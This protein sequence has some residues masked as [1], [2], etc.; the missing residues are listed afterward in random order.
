MRLIIT[1]NPGTGKTQVAEWLAK[2]LR[3]PLLSLTSFILLKKLYTRRGKQREVALGR[4]RRALLPVIRKNP[5]LIVEGHL[6]CEIRL[7]VDWVVV[8]RCH[9]KILR[10][11]LKKRRYP[12]KKLEEN[13]LAEM[14]DYTTQRAR[15]NYTVPILEIDTAHRSVGRAGRKILQ[16]IRLKKQKLESISYKQELLKT[17]GLK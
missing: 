4:L 16:A 3:Y 7:P 2:E 13:L 9:P 12:K 11:R 15:Q 14:L 5:H 17:L 10:K 1:G 6:A 8:L